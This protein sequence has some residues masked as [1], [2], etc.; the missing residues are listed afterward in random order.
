M[1]RQ[2]Y[3]YILSNRRNTVLYTGFTSDLRKRVFLHKAKL[4]DSFTK[5]YNIDKLVYYEVHEDVINAI[6]REK[7][8]KGGSR[9]K[10][11]KLIESMNPDW[12]DLYDE[13][14]SL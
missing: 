9:K 11:V 5:R 14:A 13:I 2:Y 4:V 8:I 12:K 3:V 1:A 7:Q 6:T 10:K